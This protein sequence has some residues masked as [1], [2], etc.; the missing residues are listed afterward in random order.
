MRKKSLKKHKL[1]CLQCCKIF[2]AYWALWCPQCQRARDLQIIK[3]WNRTHS[4][5]ILPGRR[6]IYQK[7]E[8]FKNWKRK[9][10]AKRQ[11]EGRF[12]LDNAMLCQ[13]WNIL[14]TGKGSY[15]LL[16]FVDWELGEVR[17]HFE[18][19]F[20]GVMSWENYGTLWE[21]NHKEPRCIFGYQTPDEDSFRE[22]W[23]LD[24]LRPVLRSVSRSKVAI[25]IAK[26]RKGLTSVVSKHRI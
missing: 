14:K 8:Q 22:C 26:E 19:Q 6:R 10:R 23:G 4:S 5:T 24:N 20:V 25:K 3:Q 16:F 2:I 18:K 7:T 9:N 1:Q 21:A 11:E 13:L 17:E 12:R 15:R